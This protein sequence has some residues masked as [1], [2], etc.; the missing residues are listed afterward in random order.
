VRHGPG[1]DAATATAS[2]AA[3]GILIASDIATANAAA[4][5]VPTR[6]L[7]A[8]AA[9]A[10]VLL[11]AT[12]Y[13]YFL[14]LLS[15]A[16]LLLVR[17]SRIAALRVTFSNVHSLKWCAKNDKSHVL[18]LSIAENKLAK[19]HLSTPSF[20]LCACQKQLTHRD[21]FAATGIHIA[22]ANAAPTA[23]PTTVPTAI[24]ANGT[25]LLLLLAT[26]TFYCYFVLLL[27]C[28]TAWAGHHTVHLSRIAALRHRADCSSVSA[29]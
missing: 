18:V 8:V 12:L 15:T 2:S 6:G 14:Q 17:L 5:A 16:T 26:A 25:V 23:V 11:H 24:G 21:G 1:T 10:T 13:C 22:T 7:T 19:C 27:Y 3:T 29:C 9:H 4:T 28:F 20:I